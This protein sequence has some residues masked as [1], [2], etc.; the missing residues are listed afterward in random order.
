MIIIVC[1]LEIHEAYHSILRLQKCWEMGECSDQKSRT[2]KNDVQLLFCRPCLHLVGWRWPLEELQNYVKN[3]GKREKGWYITTIYT[4]VAWWYSP[5]HWISKELQA[6]GK[7]GSTGTGIIR[8]AVRLDS[9]PL[10]EISWVEMVGLPTFSTAVDWGRL[11]NWTKLG[12]KP[13][14]LQMTL[15]LSTGI[16]LLPQTTLHCPTS[17][18][19]SKCPVELALLNVSLASRKLQPV[20]GKSVKVINY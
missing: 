4:Y 12:L 13:S 10:H 16:R 14:W 5:P 8:Q 1:C 3:D 9:F 11:F 6:T 18:H 20:A 15:T 17:L 19:T 2:K 7:I